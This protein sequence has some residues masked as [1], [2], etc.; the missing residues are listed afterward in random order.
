[1][2]TIVPYR[3]RK[4]RVNGCSGKLGQSQRCIHICREHAQRSKHN[5]TPNYQREVCL[6]AQVICRK[7]S[8][9]EQVLYPSSS[10]LQLTLITSPCSKN[11]QPSVFLNNLPVAKNKPIL[12]FLVYKIFN[13]F[14][15]SGINLPTTDEQCYHTNLQKSKFI[16]LIDVT[17]YAMS[18]PTKLDDFENSWLC[19]TAIWI[20]DRRYRRNRSK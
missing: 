9:L 5:I 8:L 18:F 12:I 2:A 7:N 13:K 16:P 17:P 4:D 11:L 6:R 20:W 19:C 15:V 1:M 10:S 14:E 3:V